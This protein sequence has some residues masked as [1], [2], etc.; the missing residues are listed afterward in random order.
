MSW[1]FSRLDPDHMMV[2]GNLAKLFKNENVKSAFLFDDEPIDDAAGL[3]VR[4]VTQNAWD[5][6]L[7]ARKSDGRTPPQTSS[8]VLN[9]S[10]REAATSA[11]SSMPSS[12]ASW[13]SSVK[14]RSGK[15]QSAASA[16]STMTTAWTT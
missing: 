14:P 5:S 8:C 15:L 9:L 7:E 11:T 4:E 6:A 13:P 2:D 16:T 10:R 3:L 12:S 1:T